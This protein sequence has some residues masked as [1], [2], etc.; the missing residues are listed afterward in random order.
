MKPDAERQRDTRRRMR[1]AGF[2]LRQV[3]VHPE[4]WQAVK[5]YVDAKRKK[6]AAQIRCTNCDGSGW[7]RFEGWDRP[8]RD[9]VKCSECD[10]GKP[11]AASEA[12][13]AHGDTMMHT[14]RENV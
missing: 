4:D 11:R 6:R 3:W 2:V 13:A 1:A 7:H 12:T 14:D 10:E 9:P 8:W 5:K